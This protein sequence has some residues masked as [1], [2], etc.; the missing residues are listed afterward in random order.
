MVLQSSLPQEPVALEGGDV[1]FANIS[2]PDKAFIGDNV[3]LKGSAWIDKGP[4]SMLMDFNYYRLYYQKAGDSFW[5][6]IGGDYTAEVRNASLGTWNTQSLQP[7]QYNIK[8]AL[9]DNTPDKNTVEAIKSLNLLPEILGTNNSQQEPVPLAGTYDLRIISNPLDKQSAISFQLSTNE[10]VSIKLYD[11]LGREVKTIS[12]GE[13]SKGKH[14]ITFD[15][16]NLHNGIYFISFTTPAHTETL[17]I[18]IN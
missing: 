2:Q 5:T 3:I 18:I 15:N 4:V 14:T 12:D 1:W 17:K 10:S 13:L 6:Q 7:G 16:S 8:I 11:N 9:T